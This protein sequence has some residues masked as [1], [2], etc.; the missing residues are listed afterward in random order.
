MKQSLFFLFVWVLISLQNFYAQCSQ[1]KLLAEQGEGIDENNF[2]GNING[3]ILYLMLIPY[4][5]LIFLFRK[6]IYNFL[7]GLFKAK[8]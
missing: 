8:A 3:G 7:K 5:I 1:C 4:L 6:P 2:A